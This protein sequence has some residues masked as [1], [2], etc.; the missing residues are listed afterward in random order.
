MIDRHVVLVCTVSLLLGAGAAHAQQSMSVAVGVERIENPLLSS[1]SPG[2]ATVLRAEPSYAL[3]VLN[4]RTRSRLSLGAVL[5]RSSNTAL[6]ASRNYPS[7]GY[8]WAYSWPS[9]SLELRANLAEATTRNTEFEELGRISVDSRER[10]V[11]AGGRWSKELTAR[12]Q[13]ALDLANTRVSYD[14]A[15]L[16]GYR[17]LH[18]SSRFSWE[19]SERLVYYFEPALA[20]LVSSGTST[21]TTRKRW[22]AGLQGEL[23]PGWSVTSFV[24][25]ARTRGPISATGDVVG[26]QLAYEGVRLSPRVEWSKDVAPGSTTNTYVRTESLALR[27]G[28]RVSEWATLSAGFTRSRSGGTDGS[29]GQVSSLTL[30]NELGSQWSTTIGIEDRRASTLG[31]TSGSGI[32][33]RAAF[34]YAHPGR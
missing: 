3:E 18:V 13:L 6:I 25:Q 32:A 14:S 33:I 34:V 30:A 4:D 27:L 1:T 12:T 10:S 5:E 15:L 22:L 11:V 2:G 19:A 29:R 23:V 21:E 16:S 26:L 31:G 20:R 7:L 28:Y 17:E 9:S 24:G 8:A